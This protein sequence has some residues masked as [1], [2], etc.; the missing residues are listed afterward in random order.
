V[1]V[2]GDL[3]YI[4]SCWLHRVTNEGFTVALSSFWTAPARARRSWAYRRFDG[5]LAKIEAR[6]RGPA[7]DAVHS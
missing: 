4:P 2:A 5:A 6:D 3:I 1:A 7:S